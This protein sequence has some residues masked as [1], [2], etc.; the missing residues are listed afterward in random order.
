MKKILV[1]LFSIGLIVLT[2]KASCAQEKIKTTQLVRISPVILNISLSPGKVYV[3]DIKVENLLDI[4]LP[5]DAG[6]ESFDTDEEGNYT[7]LENGSINTSRLISWSSLDQDKFIIKPKSAETVRL[8]VTIP[9]KVPI[10]GYYSVLFFTPRLPV[11]GQYQSL[12][13]SKVGAL[14]LASIGVQDPF[15]A[16]ARITQFSPTQIIFDDNP[17]YFNFRVMNESLTH[18]TAKPFIEIKTLGKD[19]Y[20]FEPGEKIILPGKARTWKTAFQYPSSLIPIHTATLSVS[21]GNGNSVKKNIFFIYFPIKKAIILVGS[22]MVVLLVLVRRK[23]IIAA[24]R[25]L[26]FDK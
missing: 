14:M 13:S 6:M 17:L 26:I 21:T 1:L 10:G 8:T 5:I 3:Y 19:P 16:K 11:Q 9:K 15:I 2:S 20:V 12:V 25:I 23:Q 24:L 22:I 4:P 7:F 18:F